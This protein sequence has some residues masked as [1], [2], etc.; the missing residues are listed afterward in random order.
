VAEVFWGDYSH[1]KAR[2][3]LNTA[4]WRLKKVLEP[5]GVTSGTYLI[6][7]SACEIGFNYQSK[8]WLDVEVFE[9]KT[10][11]LMT[12]AWTDN[13]ALKAE[14][15]EKVLALYQGELLEG[16][17]EEWA[18]QERERLRAL[19]TKCLR[20]LMQYYK[21]QHEYDKATTYGHQILHL[22][23]LQEDVHREIM[24]MY[25]ESGQRALA[26]R[27]YA[28]CQLE[29]LRELGISPM[30]ETQQLYAQIFPETEKRKNPIPLEDTVSVAQILGQLEHVSQTIDLMKAQVQQAIYSIKTYNESETSK[31]SS[32]TFMDRNAGKSR[33][34]RRQK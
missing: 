22:D 23:S 30:E 9:Q 20:Y 11:Q 13:D 19:Y 17:Y 34:I 5:E 14:E 18:L 16:H 31:A 32:R 2:R 33:N 27:Q 25:L 10:G 4:L 12:G 21:L 28:V 24:E 29:L 15:L 26:A 8:Y 6:S 7:S 3:A 1:E